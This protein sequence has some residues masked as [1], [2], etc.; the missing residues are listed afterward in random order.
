MSTRM[1]SGSRASPGASMV[2]LRDSR[3]EQAV[4]ERLRHEMRARA[5]ADLRHRVVRVR[6][7]RVVRDME[8]LG[9]L[10]P[11]LAV[12]DQA[13]YLALAIRQRL[14]GGIVAR[15]TATGAG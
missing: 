10:R 4:A 3:G 13:H 1:Y 7:H 2:H 8:L 6:S 12:A 5:G 11:A 14:V 15:Q 9:D